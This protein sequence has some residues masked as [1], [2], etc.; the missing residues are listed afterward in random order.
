MLLLKSLNVNL[1]TDKISKSLILFALPILISGIFQQLYNTVDTVII[2]HYLGDKSLAAIGASMAVFQVIIG[3]SQGFGNGFSIVT[4]R[5]FGS[6]NE[7][8][9]KQSIAGSLIIGSMVVM[10]LMIASYFFLWD[11]LVIL[12]TPNDIIQEAYD[13]IIIIALCIGVTFIYNLLAG[14]YRAVGNSVMPL[15]FLVI[16][17]ILNILLDL[18]FVVIVGMGMKGV[19]IATILSQTV[20][21]I[22]SI[23]YIINKL[24]MIIPHRKHFKFQLSL[25]HDLF[26]Q[27]LSMAMMMSI[28][29]IGTIIMQ[30]SINHM[31]Y[32]IIAG[33]TAARRLNSL[34]LM[35]LG[36][37]SSSISTFVSQNKGADQRERILDGVKKG[38]KL[39]ALVGI[40]LAI[41]VILTSK[42]LIKSVS[43]SNDA[44]ILTTGTRYL[45][46]NAPFYLVVGVLFVMRN[47][48]Q[49]LGEKLLPLTSSV[50]ELVLK[51]AFVVLL[52]PKL[53]YFGVIISE[54]IIWIFMTVQL[55]SA[56]RKNTYLFGSAEPMST[57]DTKQKI[58]RK[59]K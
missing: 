47:T 46:W 32:Q 54:P 41:I 23:T 8:L 33:H 13:Y 36:T 37:I 39:V 7:D 38:S 19:A 50:I 59:L 48:L 1:L 6:K 20:S 31:G 40:V 12:R 43:G 45:M 44:L 34:F 42:F 27:G 16:A 29:F 21:V 52:I 22:L 9:L 3:V 35:P 2:G 49:G 14:M 57:F 25:Y 5:S 56:Y 51:V 30:Y 4:A 28:V 55:A 58:E 10:I 24:P 26:G 17:S 15:I 11:L 53:G 18:F